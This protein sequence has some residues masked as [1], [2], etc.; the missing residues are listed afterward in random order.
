MLRVRLALAVG[1]VAVAIALGLVL[2]SAPLTVAA[3][4]GVA[5]RPDVATVRRSRVICQRGETVPAGTTSIRVSLSA[6]VGP[7]IGLEV[8]VGGK[9]V[10]SGKRE[11]GWGVDETVTVPVSR[12]AQTVSDTRI[13]LNIGPLAEALQVNG[14]KAETTNGH[15]ADLLRFEYL[16]PGSRSW[17]SGASAL[18]THIG[19]TRGAGAWVAYVALAAALAAAA[20]ASSMVLR[21][22]R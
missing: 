17:L 16:R 14:E 13:C 1:L 18:A 20:L 7:S 8:L 21:E 19:V 15:R 2:T 22:L 11:A 9:L 3:T 10:T 5:A 6:N 4:N 12:V